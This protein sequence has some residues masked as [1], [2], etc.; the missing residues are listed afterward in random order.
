MAE[1]LTITRLGAGGDGLAEAAGGDVFVPFALPGETV[2]IGRDG[3]RA[4]LDSV[5]VASPDRI[6]PFCPYF[7]RCG[8]CVAQHI[9][10]DL[11]GKWKR[12]KVASALE[13]AGLSVTVEP[14]QDAHGAGRRR[15]VFHARLV[16]GATVVGFM[17]AKSHRLVPIESCPIAVPALSAAPRVAKVLAGLL[18]GGGKPLDIA[19]TATV[20]GLDVDLRGSGDPGETRRQRLIALAAELD[21]ARLSLHGEVLIERRPPASAVGPAAIVPPAGGFLQATAAGEAALAKAVVAGV[22]RAKRVVDLFA[23]IGPFSLRLAQGAE[24]HAVEVE[25]AMLAALD[26]AARATPGLR[27]VTTE[28]RDLFR[29][30][31]LPGEL[32]RFDA[33]VLDPPR[34]GAEAQIAQVIPSSLEHVVMA[35]CDPGTF[36]RDA[37]TLVAGGFAIERVLPVDQFKWSAHVEIVGVFRRA[38]R[39]RR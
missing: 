30:P 6:E 26:R 27:R 21:L 15:V 3:G 33:L 39:A 5:E 16:D 37:A 8:G 1:W 2:T 23:G 10:P 34:S 11:Y 9:G 12:A 14:L 7:G 24:V 29:R 4:R 18:T 28:A 32:D 13:R 31:L 17:E 25:R 35:S 22:G 36:A 38:R 20:A 19:V